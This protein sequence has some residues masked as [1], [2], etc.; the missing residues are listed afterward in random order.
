M[1]G[2]LSI[3]FIFLLYFAF[4]AS[5]ESSLEDPSDSPPKNPQQTNVSSSLFFYLFF[6]SSTCFYN[7]SMFSNSASFSF[8]EPI[9][10]ISYSSKMA[11][12]LIL[13]SSSFSLVLLIDLIFLPPEAMLS[14]AL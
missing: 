8:N 6:I 3:L 9:D 13:I 5:G 2:R 14:I 10:T 1:H 7:T 12:P 11:D 4:F